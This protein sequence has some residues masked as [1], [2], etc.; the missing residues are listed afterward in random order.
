M[1][2][3]V[4][5]R[6]SESGSIVLVLNAGS[7]S[8][9]IGLFE[10]HQGKI[11]PLYSQT[12]QSTDW[13]SLT[14][15]LDAV[16][17]AQLLELKRMPV[18][19][20]HRV[21]HGGAGIRDHCFINPDVIAQ[22]TQASVWAPLHNHMALLLIQYAQQHFS[23]IPQ[24][25]CFDTVFHASLPEHARRFAIAKHLREGGIERFGF[26]GLASA[27]IVRQLR[28]KKRLPQ[29]TVHAHLGAGVSVTAL[30]A[31]ISI[32]TSMGLT[33]TGGCIMAT[34]SGDLDPGLLMHLLRTSGL[35][36]NE[37]ERV[38]NQQ[39]GLLGISGLSGDMQGLHQHCSTHP[40]ARLAIDMFCIS[41]QKHILAM[42]CALGGID[43]LVFSGGIGEHDRLVRTRISEGLAWLGKIKTR[44]LPALEELEMAHISQ[45]VV[46]GINAGLSQATIEARRSD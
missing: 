18:L 38:L 26:H 40:D 15:A 45:V 6:R 9:K 32:D 13:I 10:L 25:A 27:S 41:V 42:A 16:L 11:N 34:R 5:L 29:R 46:D 36:S 12:I 8:L 44:I 39:S 19:I 22:I 1:A 14:A 20:S 17:D 30:A 2:A 23:D 4:T 3:P 33:P 31:G 7:S 43:L 21:V 24:F 28:G 37:L 35:A